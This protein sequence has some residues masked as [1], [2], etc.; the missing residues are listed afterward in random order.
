[1]RTGN[2]VRS[3]MRR[4]YESDRHFWRLVVLILCWMIFMAITKFNKFYSLLNFQTMASQFPEFG[5]MALGVM[6][7]M[8]TGGIDLSTVGVANVTSILMAFFLLRFTSET[9]SLPPFAIP[10]VFLLAILIGAICGIF[11]GFLIAKLHIPPILATLGSGELF[12]GICMVMTNGNAISKFSRTYAQ[13]INNKIGGL[14]PVQ[15]LVFLVMAGFIWFLLAKTV[16]GT[17][18]YLLGTSYSAARFSG[19]NT[20]LLLLK[21]YLLSGICAALGGIIMLANYNSA[22]AD[23][24]TVY[25]LQCILIVVLGGVNPNGGKGKIS[26]VLFAIILLRMLETGINRFPK[27]SSYYISLIW[28]G[29]LILVMVL[30]YFTEKSTRTIKKAHA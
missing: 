25:T 18:I 19:L 22:R 20:S 21:T 23:Y 30:N 7:C 6:V 11:N 10:L 17:K 1:M 26:G 8:I 16:F 9:G 3:T 13:T 14:V 4:T 24:G 2:S 28:G 5:L 12:T 27:V 29:V 15:L